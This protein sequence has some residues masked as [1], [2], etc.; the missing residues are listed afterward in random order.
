MP[1]EA[2]ETARTAGRGGVAVLAAK[3]YFIVAGLLQQVL[4]PRMITLAGY[5]ALARVLSAGNIVNNVVI[6]T[7]TQ[8]VSRAVAH[9]GDEAPAAFRATL[10][11]HAILAVGVASLFALAS[12]AVVWFQRAPHIQVPLLVLSGVVLMYGFYAPLVGY[13]NGRRLFTAQAALDMAFATM[14]TVGLLGLGYVFER[15]DHAGVTGALVGFVLAATLIVPLALRWTGIGQAAPKD[16]TARAVVPETGAYLAALLPLAGAQFFTNL[17]LQIDLAILG[18]F[19]SVGAA[20]SAAADPRVADEWVG[21]YRACQLFAFLPYQLLAAVTQVLFP[22]VARAKAAG[23]LEGVR[24]YVA[25]GA[26]IAAIAAGLLVSF[27]LAAPGSLLSFAFTPNVAERGASTLRILAAGQGLFALMNVGTTALASIGME[28]LAAAVTALASVAMVSACWFAGT[29]APFGAPML[30]ATATATAL[31]LGT[32]L[33]TC[34]FT[35]K[36][37]A[38]AFLPVATALRVALAL[39]LATALG[40]F[41]P[42]VSFLPLVGYEL[43]VAT[44]YVAFLV[45]TR[46]LGKEDLALVRSV[47]SGR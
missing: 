42:R 12:P 17:L 6:A 43:A 39:A 18:R 9:A 36:R 25:R 33:A 21:V 47:L 5:G 32:A 26:R 22:M 34:A 14:R 2:E 19:L 4:L 44:A 3:V 23:D 8:G 46:E 16:A 29:Q 30:E 28:R 13:L 45:V 27:V 37:T 15:A 41:V 10:R 24:R 35:V 38:G 40:L 31:A 20:G 1:S 7:S 11:L